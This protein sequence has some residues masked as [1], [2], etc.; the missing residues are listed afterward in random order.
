[1]RFLE[2]ADEPDVL[3]FERRDDN[4]RIVVL[5]N[6]GNEPTALKAPAAGQSCRILLAPAQGSTKTATSSDCPAAIAPY[7]AVVVAL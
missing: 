2:H 4:E 5:L 1:M 6:N 7:S 3:E